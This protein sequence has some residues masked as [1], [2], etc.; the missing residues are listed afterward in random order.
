MFFAGVWFPSLPKLP[1]G[2]P[3]DADGARTR[4][5]RID[6]PAK[7]GPEAGQVPRRRGGASC[8]SS[9]DGGRQQAAEGPGD[10][11]GEASVAIS[12]P[13]FMQGIRGGI[14][15]ER[16]KIDEQLGQT[17]RRGGVIVSGGSGGE[18]V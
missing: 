16:A 7:R 18:L 17:M 3:S 12:Q 11:P 9:R 13:Q 5:H 10:G 1:F 15:P 8:E 2:H 6:S 4:N 14:A